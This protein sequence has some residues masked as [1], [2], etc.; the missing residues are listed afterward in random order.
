MR[1]ALPKI[2]TVK[3]RHLILLA[4]ILLCTIVLWK[5]PEAWGGREAASASGLNAGDHLVATAPTDEGAAR[6]LSGKS[7]VRFATD[8]AATH[9]PG[10]LVQFYLP[11]VNINGLPLEAALKKLQAAYEDACRETGETPLALTFSV[12]P[13][14][15]RLL[16][17]KIGT[18]TLDGAIR[19][20]A[21]M[22]GMHL[23]RKGSQYVF[24]L[25]VETGKPRTRS[26]RVPPDFFNAPG[27]ADDPFVQVTNLSKTSPADYFS[28]K[29]ITLD[30]D[31]RL[32]FS[33]GA[34]TLV[35]DTTRAADEVAVAQM[36]SLASSET[37]PQLKVTTKILEL[38]KDVD[39]TPP[40]NAQLD[41]ASMQLLMR[42]LAQTRGVDLMTAPSTVAGNGQ[43]AKM[44]I[45]R[46]V[47]S[48]VPG[49]DGEFTVE[50]VGV[51]LDFKPAVLG[52]GQKIDMGFNVTDVEEDP[53]SS[54]LKVVERASIT[55]S[56]FT[57]DAFTRIHVE[58]R[59]DG[60]RILLLVTPTL[61]DA[62][63]RPVRSAE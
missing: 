14:H 15:D 54:E 11:P 4:V 53:K 6:Q 63:G 26:F 34:G 39:W 29:G 1:F 55:D 49:S 50:P 18:R 48:P 35:M 52:F 43:T 20:L 32:K 47:V 46:E 33:P 27:S 31:T 44:E 38:G 2:A 42:E 8:P 19:L 56:S 13:G 41:E 61:I 40:E 7:S 59:P 60:S 30:P 37:I 62:T 25:P 36:V 28:N 57:R 16:T 21:A 58:T 45:V 10:R 17:V 22:S 23:E 9:P 51:V 24:E 3:K 5:G 12:P